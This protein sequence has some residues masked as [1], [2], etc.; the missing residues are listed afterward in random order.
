MLRLILAVAF[1]ATFAT[2]EPVWLPGENGPLFPLGFYEHPDT[3]EGLDAMAAAGVNVLRCNNTDQLDD[4]ADHG[5]KAWVPLPFQSGPDAIVDKVEAVKDHPALAVWEGPDEIVW[6]FTAYSGLEEKV[7]VSREDWN[8][9]QP[10]AVAYAREQAATIMP[11]INA[12][13]ELIRER[14]TRNLPVWINEARS[15]DAAYVRM[16]QDAVDVIGADDYPVRPNGTDLHRVARATD[17]WTALSRDE[18]V[19]MVL[20]A[21]SW[22]EIDRG[23]AP[24]WPTFD[25]ARY[26]A[27]TCITHGATGLLWWGSDYLTND[28]F[29]TAQY[30]V[31]RE[32]AKLNDFLVAPEASDIRVRTIEPP[33]HDIVHGVRHIA[34]KVGDEWLIVLVNDDD[35][36][37]MGTEVSGLDRETGKKFHVLYTDETLTVD[38]HGS[39]ITRLQPYQ[40]KVLATSRAHQSPNAAGRDYDGK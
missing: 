25:Q 2:A 20:Q 39:F 3:S 40:V 27:W 19:W 15:S 23:D 4:A 29:R 7:G 35:F 9:Q 31:V 1:G 14:D 24:A 13:I 16:Y 37:H 17:Y 18:A 34:R 30:A 26:M 28:N 33:D 12:S 11:N 10:N 32:L 38:N 6:M 8:T 36:A 22:D 5:M 21:F